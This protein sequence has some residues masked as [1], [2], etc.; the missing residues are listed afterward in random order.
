MTTSDSFYN[1]QV[2]VIAGG[3]GGAKLVRGLVRAFRAHSLKIITNTADD[4]IFHGLHVSPDLDTMLYTLV[5]VS[6]PRKGWGV[7]GDSFH[8]LS[9]L[10]DYGEPTWFNLGDRDLATHILRTKMLKEGKSLTEVT[11]A[12]SKRLGLRADILPMTDQRVETL[13]KTKNGIVPF[14]VY[15]VRMQQK[16]KVRG[17]SFRG[18]RKARCTDEVRN[19]IQN[20]SLIIIAPSNP[21][22]SVLPVLSVHPMKRLIRDS[23]ALKIAVSPFIGKRAIS[24]PAKELMESKG[25][26]GSSYGLASFYAG[27]ID[28]LVIHYAD[29]REKK[30]IEKTGALVVMT[31]TLMKRLGDSVRLAKRIFQIFRESRNSRS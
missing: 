27:L 8:T 21:I 4:T 29:H 22:V 14:Q 3:V 17:V 9:Q 6:D 16:V 23:K 28:V 30:I 2:T 10:S 1:R 7:R 25:Y 31:D 18:I 13:V 12:L 26:E 24:G 11:L 15:F 19:A 20:T 5:G